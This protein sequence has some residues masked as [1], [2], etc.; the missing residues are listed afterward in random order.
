MKDGGLTDRTAPAFF[1]A[2][3]KIGSDYDHR[4]VLQAIAQSTV[5]DGALAQATATTAGMSSDY[6]RAESLVAI[7]HSKA[8][9]PSTRKALAEAA[10]AIGSEHD[11]G[12]VLSALSKAGVLI[13]R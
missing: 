8:V 2:L 7:S 6:D 11:R 13:T 12:R 5:S 10:N 3:P 9:G 4:R 1:M